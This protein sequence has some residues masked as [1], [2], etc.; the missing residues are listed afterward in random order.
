[1][2]TNNGSSAILPAGKFFS[3]LG[4]S[5]IKPITGIR[6]EAG[7]YND[8]ANASILAGITVAILSIIAVIT[9]TISFAAWGNDY[10]DL[11]FFQFMKWFVLLIIK[12]A[13]YTFGLAGI[14]FIAGTLVGKHPNYARLLAI[15]TL[16]IIGGCLVDAL[17]VPM[18]SFLS[19]GLSSGVSKAVLVYVIIS[20]Y[21]GVNENLGLNDNQRIYISVTALGI[22]YLFSAFL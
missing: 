19:V 16:G 10:F 11:E 17:I 14:Y 3:S 22:V 8:I 9:K 21:E 12:Y 4:K 7:N 1:M 5:A 20:I 18:F 15:C 6:E 13:T 2:T